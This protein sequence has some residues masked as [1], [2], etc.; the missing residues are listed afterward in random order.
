[1]TTPVLFVDDEP[2]VLEGIRRQLRG[3]CE[4]ET[5]VGAAEGIKRVESGREFAV[6]VSDMRMPDIDGAAFLAKVRAAKPDIVRIMLT[7]NN[8]LE[9]AIRAVNEGSI[10]RFL[11]KPCDKT[12]LVQTVA[13]AQRQYQLITAER[14]LLERTV[15]G[16]VKVL[17]D[18]LALIDPAGFG[19]SQRL[20]E[21]AQMVG[22]ELYPHIALELELAAL[23][24]GI[25]AVIL[26]AELSRKLSRGDIL[27]KEEEKIA[28]RVPQVSRDLLAN[29]PRLEGVAEAVLYQ[30]KRFDGGGAPKDGKA[31]DLI[32]ES[33][34]VL[35][36]LRD[37]LVVE[38]SGVSRGSA[39]QQLSERVGWYDP[40]IV[41]RIGGYF[42]SVAKDRPPQTETVAELKVSELTV[43]Q[44][45]LTDVF[46]RN[47]ILLIAAGNVVTS[48]VL[49]R[50]QNYSRLAGVKEP[51][52]VKQCL[53]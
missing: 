43:G 14:E 35:R 50:L 23:L 36:I 51:I 5:A 25:G 49:E 9:T 29:I 22:R 19:R 44:T 47:G 41:E 17:A 33:A 10:F 34:R 32:P 8:D 30:N 4:I 48:T 39:V 18:V 21:L 38:A 6:V 45:L 46:A 1:M 42:D 7:G 13:D 15:K 2:N 26:P 11:S 20:S 40:I 27:N 24:S 28:A 31:R 16:S 3:I 37:C 53:T 12:L 52:R